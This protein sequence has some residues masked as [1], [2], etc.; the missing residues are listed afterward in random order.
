MEFFENK[1]YYKNKY[2][3]FK[4][5]NDDIYKNQMKHLLS[6][7]MKKNYEKSEVHIKKIIHTQ[8]VINACIKSLNK[9][10]IKIFV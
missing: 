7:V 5:N 1:V 3:K 9:K 8:N 2:F 6:I 10:A 4:L